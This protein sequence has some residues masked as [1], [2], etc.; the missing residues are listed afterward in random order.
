MKKNTS[1]AEDIMQL[2]LVVVGLVAGG[3]AWAYSTFQTKETY[4]DTQTEIQRRLERIETKLDEL[5]SRSHGR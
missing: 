5:V 1:E 4:R 2:L 3:A